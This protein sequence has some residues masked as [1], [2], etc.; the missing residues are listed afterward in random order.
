MTQNIFQQR[1]SIF[2][3]HQ[4]HCLQRKSIR[5]SSPFSRYE[6]KRV[7]V[8]SFAPRFHQIGELYSIAFFTVLV[9]ASDA[10]FQSCGPNVATNALRRRKLVCSKATRFAPVGPKVPKGP[11]CVQ[12]AAAMAFVQCKARMRQPQTQRWRRNSLP[13]RHR[14]S[15]WGPSGGNA[16]CCTL[17]HHQLWQQ[18]SAALH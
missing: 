7:R 8:A 6:G 13:N 11:Q 16:Y 1:K 2:R 5:F 18:L 3:Q 17:W 14:L 10:I 9:S 15:S 4:K 12:H